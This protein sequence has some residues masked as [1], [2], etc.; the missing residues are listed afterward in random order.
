MW[1]FR[2]KNSPVAIPNAPTREMIDEAR[3]NPN[4]WVYVIDGAYG[5]SDAVPPE[6]IVGAWKVDASGNLTGEYMANANYKRNAI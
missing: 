5:P 6:H 1:P 4:G 3:R 2:K